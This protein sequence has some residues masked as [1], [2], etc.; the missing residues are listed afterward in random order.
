MN[1]Y[2]KM[3][4]ISIFVVIGY[5]KADE[6]LTL[7]HSEQ[8]AIENNY[9]VRSSMVQRDVLKWERNSVFGSLLPEVSFSTSYLDSEQIQ[10]TVGGQFPDDGS[11]GAGPATPTQD[12]FNHQLA[13]NQPIFNGG[14]EVVGVLMA[15]DALYAQEYRIEQAR[16]DAI[17]QIRSLYLNAVVL[18]ERVRIERLGLEW[19]MGSLKRALVGYEEGVL[20]ETEVLRW[21]AQK[22]ERRGALLQSLA[23]AQA[24]LTQLLLTMGEPV[25]RRPKITLEGRAFVEKM[26][27]AL[28]V[29]SALTIK[30]NPSLLAAL[31]E[32]TVARRSVQMSLTA[33]LPRLNAFFQYSWPPS[34]DIVPQEDGFWTLGVRMDLVLFS[35]VQRYFDYR[36]SKTQHQS[37]KISAEQ[38]KEG[39]RASLYETE[40]LYEGSVQE[41]EAARSRLDLM[42]RTFSIVERRY[43]A[44]VSDILELLDTRIQLESAEV[45]YL[46]S[47]VNSIINR[48]EYLH[49]A[50]EL[51]AMR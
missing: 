8:A 30:N 18:E 20:P 45:T 10:N 9:Q 44:G 3:L 4:P 16:Q 13:V 31:E 48:S 29:S 40:V 42:E 15:R 11:G 6:I 1:E 21:E 28:T 43:E 49:A 51:K 35:G 23:A 27:A 14:S 41:V 36:G 46:V 39:L 34:D 17:L 33:F 38:L 25:E 19:V 32:L 37:L 7:G 47:M 5:V 22:Y 24:S 12:G 50:G 26:Y 2:I